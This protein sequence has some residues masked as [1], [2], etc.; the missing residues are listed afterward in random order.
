MAMVLAG[1]LIA[2]VEE[3]VASSSDIST[4]SYVGKVDTSL[5]EWSRAGTKK[6][7]NTR[8]AVN[9]RIGHIDWYDTEDVGFRVL[10]RR[11]GSSDFNDAVPSLAKCEHMEPVTKVS[12]AKYNREVKREKCHV[13]IHNFLPGYESGPLEVTVRHTL[14]KELCKF[15]QRPETCCQQAFESFTRIRCIQELEETQ[16]KEKITR[17]QRDYRDALEKF[18]ITHIPVSVTPRKKSSPKSVPTTDYRVQSV[19]KARCEH[20]LSAVNNTDNKNG[21]HLFT[22]PFGTIDKSLS[23]CSEG[24]EQMHSTHMGKPCED[25]VFSPKGNQNPIVITTSSVKSLC[26]GTDIDE[27]I[28]D[29]CMKW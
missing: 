27:D 29:L 7:R 2:M 18:L 13:T 21:N 17:Q 16:Q 3:V 28:L 22:F 15:H 12:L 5:W 4:Y 25:S 23:C 14:L 19:W 26:P 9:G 1:R 8:S 10:V 11:Q 24:L 6:V 20:I